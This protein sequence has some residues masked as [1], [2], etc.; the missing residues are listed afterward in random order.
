MSLEDHLRT[1]AAR[2]ELKRLLVVQTTGG[3]QAAFN[4]GG[5][6]YRIDIREDPV[7]AILNVLA[8]PKIA[9]PAP[10]TAEEDVFG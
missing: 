5:N 7:A 1:L 3:F 8:P 6:S 4:V 9:D 2:G 10:A